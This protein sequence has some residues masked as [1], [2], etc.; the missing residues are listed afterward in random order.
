MTDGAP[1]RKIHGELVPNLKEWHAKHNK[2]HY[3]FIQE[4]LRTHDAYIAEGVI[5]STATSAVDEL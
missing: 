2:A 5:G 1:A 3:E 4:H